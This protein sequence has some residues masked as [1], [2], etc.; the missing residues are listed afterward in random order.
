MLALGVLAGLV[1][2]A[3]LPRFQ[4]EQLGIAAEVYYHAAQAALEGEDFYAVYPPGLPGYRFIYPPIVVVLFLPHALAG[5][6]AASFAIQTV[7]NLGAALGFAWLL[8]RALERR[9]VHLER[10][11]RLLVVAFAVCSTWWASQ[12]VMGQTTPWL[13]IAIAGGLDALDR[14]RS[15][16]AGVVVGLAALVKVFPAVLGVWF[17]RRRASAAVVAALATGLAGLALGAFAF[18]VDTSVQY[19]TE[20]LLGRHESETFAATPDPSTNLA[21]ARRQVA[22]VVGGGSSLVVPLTVA[23]VAPPVAYCYRD[24]GSDVRRLAAV[25]ATLVGTLLVLP[26][27]PLY[28][29]LLAY[30][31][32]LL[33][34][35]LPAG[36]ARALLLAGTLLTYLQVKQDLLVANLRPLPAAATEP[37]LAVTEVLFVVALPPTVGAWLLLAGSVAI[38]RGGDGAPAVVPEGDAGGT[39]DVGST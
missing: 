9:D 15:R 7:A 35:R 34:F 6:P 3:T 29:S 39:R 22:A 2:L 33:L 26:L 36:R 19:V 37:L 21:T 23:A 38:H 14:D 12:F 20:V 25:L 28:Y 10:V 5:S 13:A 8:L 18:G 31:L 24:V 16:V 1:T 32:L 4:P 17:L 27:Q 30:P 11:D